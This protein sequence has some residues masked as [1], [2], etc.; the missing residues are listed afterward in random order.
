ME[1]TRVC[2]KSLTSPIEV[3]THRPR[4]DVTNRRLRIDAAPVGKPWTKRIVSAANRVRLESR[5]RIAY[6]SNRDHESRTSRIA[7]T[8]RRR[9]PPVSCDAGHDSLRSWCPY[10]GGTRTGASNLNFRR[11][12]RFA[13]LMVSLHG[14][15]TRKGASGFVPDFVLAAPASALL[16]SAPLSLSQL[17]LLHLAGGVSG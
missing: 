5:S 10:T 1:L 16:S 4:I 8:N 3:T 17:E 14:G 6:V 7:I 2:R 12:T 15:G 9:V 11:R 13:P